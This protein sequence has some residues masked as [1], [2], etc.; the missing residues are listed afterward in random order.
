MAK[1]ESEGEIP[2][3]V[4][5]IEKS[6][7]T[8]YKILGNLESDI[9]P[10]VALHGGPGA[11]HEYLLPLKD[12]TDQAG[13]PIILYDQLGNGKSTRLRDKMGDE[14]FWTE[15][16]F[17]LELDNLL[18]YFGLHDSGFDLYG[19]SWGGMLAVK[20]AALRPKGL[21]KLVLADAPASVELLL[22]GANKLRKELPADVQEV[23][24][25]CEREGDF[26]SEEY[27]QAF[28]VFFKRHLCRLE[29]VPGGIGIALGHL[30]ED[31]TVYQTMYGPSELVASGSLKEWT[32]IEDI[33][34]IEAS[35]LL[36]NG[37]Y[38]EVQDLAV[39]PFFEKLNKVKW[40]TLEKSSHMGHFEERE[41]YMEV[42]KDFL[43]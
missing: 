2:F 17:R 39:A 15:D 16:L 29:P 28:L 12:L 21:R 3:P 42:L 13:T 8:Y 25:R 11:C 32:A 20:Y 22:V 1:L 5:G 43:R 9:V 18:Q 36:I 33:H 10:L 40:I 41:R 31:P 23:L 14:S 35:T 6:C 27:E 24:E 7:S 19:H 38:D 37:R 34:K 4:P 30:K 26:E